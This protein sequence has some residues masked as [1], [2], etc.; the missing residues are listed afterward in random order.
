[1]LARLSGRVEQSD[2]LCDPFR[3]AWDKGVGWLI[4]EPKGRFVERYLSGDMAIVLRRCEPS[5]GGETVQDGLVLHIPMEAL[6]SP[7]FGLQSEARNLRPSSQKPFV[8]SPDIE[9]MEGIQKRVPAF[10]RH[11]RFDSSLFILG[12]PRFAFNTLGA[13]ERVQGAEN[14]KVRFVA[15]FYAIPS[16]E[17][18]S[19]QVEATSK[20]IDNRS[21]F[22]IEEAIKRGLRVGSEELEGRVSI[23]LYHEHIR[24]VPLP[25]S[26]SLL[27][28]WDLGYGPINGSLSV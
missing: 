15:R 19:N 13:E 9:L 12:K 24:A 2:D 23:R 25:G 7:T 14:W 11:E 10:V 27:D 20:R 17:S 28:E 5:S 22:G 1:M 16:S 21:S 26:E 6:K 4:D 18:G 3:K 8:F